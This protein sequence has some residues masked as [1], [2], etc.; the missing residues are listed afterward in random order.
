M[1]VSGFGQ[2]RSSSTS[3]REHEFG[4]GR[5][6]AGGAAAEDGRVA[7]PPNA[8]QRAGQLAVNARTPLVHALG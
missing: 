6:P 1:D 2:I 8:A 5:P 4:G 3:V 7:T